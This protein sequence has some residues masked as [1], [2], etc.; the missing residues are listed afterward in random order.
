MVLESFMLQLFMY[1]Y[2]NKNLSIDFSAR[3][4]HVYKIHWKRWAERDWVWV[5]DMTTSKI[6]A[7]ELPHTP[8]KT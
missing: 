8:V 6:I 2:L 4:G 5:E 3:P 1:S 7:G